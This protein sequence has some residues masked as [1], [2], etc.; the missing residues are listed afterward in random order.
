MYAIRSY[1]GYREAVNFNAFF[2][3]AMVFFVAG[4]ATY[5]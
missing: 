1:Y 5:T 3:Q 4:G 2:A